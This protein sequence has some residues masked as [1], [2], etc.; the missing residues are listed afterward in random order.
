[1]VKLFENTVFWTKI[2]YFLAHTP[3]GKYPRKRVLTWPHIWSVTLLQ[4]WKWILG[5]SKD[6]L[7]ILQICWNGKWL[8]TKSKSSM[9]HAGLCNSFF[10]STSCHRQIHSR[11]KSSSAKCEQSWKSSWGKYRRPRPW[12]L[13]SEQL[14]NSKIDAMC[15]QLLAFSSF[16]IQCDSSC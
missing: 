1:M 5:G 4:K 2:Q 11:R 3:F 9:M 6:A 7:P 14:S 10:C 15:S 8:S 16:N 12:K 13:P